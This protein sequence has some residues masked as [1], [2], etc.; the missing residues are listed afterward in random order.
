[1]KQQ[2]EDYNNM[3]KLIIPLLLLISS[4]CYSQQTLVQHGDSLWYKNF[5]TGDSFLITYKPQVI[6]LIQDS[7]AFQ[8]TMSIGTR[9]TT[10]PLNVTNFSTTFPTP[11]SGTMV[12]VVSDA[13]INGRVSFDVYNNTSFTGPV[14][15]GRRARGTAG[16]PTPPI[17]DD[18]LVAIGADGYGTSS[19]TGSSVGSMNIRSEATFTNTSK[20]TYISFTTTP[21]A[22]TTQAERMRISSTGALQFT[23][24]GSGTFAGTATKALNVDA[25]GNIIEGTLPASSDSTTFQTKFRSDTGRTNTYTAIAGK[26][27]L[28]DSATY[29][30]KFRSDSSRTNIYTSLAGKQPTITTG[31]TAQYLKGDLSLGTYSGY[32][33]SVQAL[34]SSP[35]D[36]QTIYFGNMP[37][38]P[39]T[40]QGTSKIYI[41]QAGTIKRAEIYCYSGTA[42]TNEAWPIYIRLN[43]SGDTQIASLSV[44]T[45]E[46]VFSNTSLSIAVAA[47][48]YIEIK[49][50]NPTWATN[51]LTCI[52]GGY[53]Y[54]E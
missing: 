45:N 16:S 39:V 40:T 27:A 9:L 17:T 33:L 7:S 51:P 15:Q 47:G 10:S 41:R 46:R 49:S 38:T 34:T 23:N 11:Q 3:K 31:T 48:D 37:K 22:S 12:H 5:G 52:F 13:A 14:Y 20:P 44:A 43:N 19:Y 1:M 35:T 32:T 54:I 2:P 21:T 6:S 8:T 50:I 24:Y 18:V 36:A 4:Q 42:G 53:V 29:Y 30:T 25:S 28:G 26:Q